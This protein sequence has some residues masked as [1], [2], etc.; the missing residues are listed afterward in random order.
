MGR[1]IIPVLIAALLLFTGCSQ[2]KDKDSG[3]A[4]D[5]STS[6]GYDESEDAEDTSIGDKQQAYEENSEGPK[7]DF[8]E[9]KLAI[10]LYYQDKDGYLI[11]VTRRVEKQEGIAKAALNALVDNA[12]NREEI[13]YFG[14]YP[15]LPEGTK[16]LGMTIKEGTARVDF[17][18]KLLDYSSETDERNIIT[19]IVYTL[20]EFS[21]IND[22]KILINGYE[23]GTLKYGTD[24]SG[25]LG[26][27]NVMINNGEVNVEEGDGKLDVYLFKPLND[28][29]VYILPVSFKTEILAEDEKPERI[30]ELLREGTKDDKLFTEIPG[31]TELIKSDIK[32][33]LLILDFDSGITAY[34]GGTSREDGILKQILYSMKQVDG[35]KRVRIM[36]EGGTKSL[37]EGTD[38]SK[39]MLIPKE[40]ND[41]VDISD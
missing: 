33:N 35:I 12:L 21:T 39:P 3:N 19:S 28:E 1:F 11:P 15:V 18:N 41:V 7:E 2:S 16:I 25:T 23:L 6:T 26:R 31:E 14:L 5:M 37:P 22:V 10:T 29:Y 38:I 20:T 4:I 24:A 17:N 27:Q 9:E 40:I 8:V 30:I 36:I 32:D 13:E 34:G